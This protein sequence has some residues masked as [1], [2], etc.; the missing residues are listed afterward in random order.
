MFVHDDSVKFPKMRQQNLPVGRVYVVDEGPHKGKFYPS[1]TRVLKASP[2]PQ[3]EAWKKRVGRAESER[4]RIAGGNRGTSIHNIAE[5]YIAN[6][7]Q[8]PKFMPHVGELWKHLRPALDEHL[9]TIYAMEQNVFSDYLQVAGRLDI[10]GE[11]DDEL[12]VVDLK[13]SK[14][15]KLPESDV[16]KNYFAQSTF[17]ALS[18]YEQTGIKVKKV[19]LPIV[20]PEGLSIYVGHVKEYYS[21]LVEK[22]DYFY[23]SYEI[24]LDSAAVEC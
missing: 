15:T 6:E 21:R 3:L 13:N 14:K 1:I 7:P 8:L 18:I 22:I 9:G 16:V 19:V 17:Y 11:W 4:Q 24:E 2:Q 10:F 12:A 20:S 5:C 23:Q